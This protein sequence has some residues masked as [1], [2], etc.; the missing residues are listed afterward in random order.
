MAC[1]KNTAERRKT[2]SKETSTTLAVRSARTFETK[3]REGTVYR[4]AGSGRKRKR[5]VILLRK[6]PVSGRN[7]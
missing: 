5:G 2:L 3:K 6:T 4:Q 1:Y 7:N